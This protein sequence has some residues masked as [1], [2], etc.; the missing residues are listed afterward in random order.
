MHAKVAAGAVRACLLALCLGMSGSAD[1]VSPQAEREIQALIATLADS[2]CRFERNGSWY[3]GKRAAAHLQ[4]KYDYL[5]KRDPATTPESFIANAA[6]RSSVTGQAYRVACPGQ[7]QA[8]AQ[9]WFSA[10]LRAQRATP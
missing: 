1:A 5:R 6:S 7:P 3:D 2:P 9:S 10:R 4:R 8:D